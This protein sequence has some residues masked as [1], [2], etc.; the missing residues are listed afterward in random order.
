MKFRFISEHLE[1]FNVGRMCNLLNVSRSGFYDW[2]KRPECSRS[3]Q[4]RT[5][6]DRIR[7][8]HANSHGIYG[9]PRI[10][11]DLNDAG[12]RCGKNRVAR[13]M[14]DGVSEKRTIN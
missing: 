6:E 3:R 5:L 2:K 8:L 7:L 14:R 4:N 1:T 9:A 10:H 11:R 12:V 13:I